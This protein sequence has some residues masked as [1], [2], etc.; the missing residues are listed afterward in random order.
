MYVPL[1]N[2][3][4]GQEQKVYFYLPYSVLTKG[5]AFCLFVYPGS[6]SSSTSARAHAHRAADAFLLC[7][8]VTDPASLSNALSFWMAEIRGSSNS[9]TA[10]APVILVGCQSDL[11]RDRDVLASLAKRGKAPI[12]APQALTFSQQVHNYIQSTFSMLMHKNANFY[13]FLTPSRSAPKCTWRR[14]PARPPATPSPPLRWP[15]S[16]PWAS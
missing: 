11:R 12:S 1:F 3:F 8:K 10:G 16:P 5:I 7:F 13:L 4:I 14:A 15:P 9:A 6:H 2:I